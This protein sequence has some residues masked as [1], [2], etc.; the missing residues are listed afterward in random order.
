MTSKEEFFEVA[1]SLTD[2]YPDFAWCLY[3]EALDEGLLD[4][5]YAF[6]KENAGCSTDEVL[7]HLDNLLGNPR[8]L[9]GI[10]GENESRQVALAG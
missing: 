3:S 2:V 1:N 8:P 5:I 7:H 6:M 10:V 4:S 9:V